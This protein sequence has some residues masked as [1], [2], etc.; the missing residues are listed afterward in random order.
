M[1]ILHIVPG[2][3]KLDQLKQFKTSHNNNPHAVPNRSKN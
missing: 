3:W 1:A 2:M